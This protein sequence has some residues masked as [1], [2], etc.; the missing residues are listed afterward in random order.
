MGVV[1]KTTLARLVYNDDAVRKHFDPKAWV[2]VSDEFAAVKKAKTVRSA[3]SP[4][5]NDSK[6][7]NQLQVELS[8]SLVGKRFLLVLDNVWNKSYEVWNDLR[9]PF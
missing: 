5:T 8:Q 7:F 2:C 4:Q 6:D 9:I 3:I 1:G